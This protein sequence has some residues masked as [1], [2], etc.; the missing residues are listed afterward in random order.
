MSRKGVTPVIA[1]AL[2]I[3]IAVSTALS[4][5]VFMEG[6]L[7]DVQGNVEDDVTE[8]DRESDS[9]MS[10]DYGYE[11]GG[12]LLIDIR[13]TGSRAL[14]LMD[15]DTKVLSVYMEGKPNDD[16][17]YLSDREV[18]GQDATVTINTSEAFPAPG[19]ST[20]VEIRG[21]YE[22]QSSIICYNDGSGSC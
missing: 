7:S 10:I 2:L 5:M 3:G 16:W 13:N 18:L 19:N 15:N 17:D 22:T 1:T 6:T 21:A 14:D 9:E 4:A 20:E 11:Q 8:R 12:Y